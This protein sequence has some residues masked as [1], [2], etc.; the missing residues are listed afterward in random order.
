[1]SLNKTDIYKMS[2]L[3]VLIVAKEPGREGGQCGFVITN[4]LT[5]IPN[6][7]RVY[8]NGNVIIAP[9]V[10]NAMLKKKQNIKNIHLQRYVN[11][12]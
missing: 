4:D 5:N 2:D 10:T 7:S 8:Q 12:I 3:P 1:M 9:G 6:G 11:S